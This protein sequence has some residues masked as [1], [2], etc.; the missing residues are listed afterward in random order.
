MSDSYKEQIKI[1]KKWDRIIPFFVVVF[2]MFLHHV[3][4]QDWPLCRVIQSNQAEY[5]EINCSQILSDNLLDKKSFIDSI[6]DFKF[7]FE[8]KETTSYK[9]P[10]I[11]HFKST[12]I[13]LFVIFIILFAAMYGL[14]AFLVAI[15]LKC[16]LLAT[17]IFIS[18]FILIFLLSFIK[19]LP[20][21]LISFLIGYGVLVSNL[22]GYTYN[23]FIVILSFGSGI[24]CMIVIAIA[25]VISLFNG[26]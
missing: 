13:A 4:F 26:G 22:Y 18:P 17:L 15:Q 25:F 12:D 23:P 7:N 10:V 14:N 19:E 3:S 8:N 21:T 2:S 5:G 1:Y 20:K 9:P 11:T 6:K 24:A 16:F